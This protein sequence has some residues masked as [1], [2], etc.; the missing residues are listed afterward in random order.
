[1]PRFV[2]SIVIASVLSIALAALAQQPAPLIQNVAGRKT[3]SL[4]GAWHT[5]VDPYDTGYYDYRRQPTR[6]GFFKNAKPRDKQDLVEYD[7]DKS[8]TLNVPGDWNSQSDR[9][10]FYEGTIW[11]ERDFQYHPQANHRVFLYVGAANYESHVAVNGT[12]VCDHEGGFTPYNCEV[13]KLLRDGDNFVVI[14]VNNARRLDAVPTVNTDWWNYGGI[15]REVTL[16][17]EPETFVRDYYVQLAKGSRDRI[18]GWVQLDG[19]TGTQ[20]VTVRIPE[21]KVEKAVTTDAN[22]RATIDIAVPGVQLWSPDSPKLYDV[23]IAS[24]GDVVRDQM[25]F[26]TIETRGQ[27]ILLNGKPI[28]L[29]GV[30]IHEE[31]AG[32]A[33]RAWSEADDRVLLGW[34]QELGGNYVRLAHYP[35]NEHMLRLADKLGILVWAEIPVY[36]TIDFTNQQTY[37][38]AQQQLDEL[39]ARDHN[40]ASVIIWSVG[41]ETPISPPRTEFMSKLAATAHE[42]DPTRLVSAALQPHGTGPNDRE[43]SDPLGQYLDVLGC[44]EYI[45]WYEGTADTAD[46]TNWHVAYDKPLIMS[47]FGAG[48]VAGRHGATDERWTEEYQ[49]NVYTHQL[50]MLSRISNLRGM[51]PW[52][53][54]DFRSPKRLLPDI[55]DYFNRKGLVSDKGEKKKAF[56]VL[57]DAYKKTKGSARLVP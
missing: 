7:F 27:D 36:W 42:L 14:Y 55:Q 39:I 17:D 22:G 44:N 4:D 41:N 51:T 26:R 5:I 21:L 57:Q 40:R 45:G 19:V 35:H 43:I 50:Q 29:R 53:L 12:R 31:A 38:K 18:A 30:S 1:M 28:F 10:F 6:S 2:R 23:E 47:E 48:A 16:V 11:Y 20:S 3:T 34:V 9:L 32:P 37:A 49:A 56:F 33:R 8:P 13:T 54:K 24:G 52:I 46:H 25:G 15:T